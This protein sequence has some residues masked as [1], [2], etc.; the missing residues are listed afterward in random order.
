MYSWNIR[1][2]YP[3]R[4]RS[5]SL[6]ELSENG[7]ML[8]SASSLLLPHRLLLAARNFD[9]QKSEDM[10][11]KVRPCAHEHPVSYT[12][13][14][15]NYPQGLSTKAGASRPVLSCVSSSLPLHPFLPQTR[16]PHSPRPGA[17]TPSPV[18]VPLGW[19]WQDPGARGQRGVACDLWG[20]Q[21]SGPAVP[22]QHV[23]FRKLQ[24]LDNILQ[25]KPSEVSPRGVPQATAGPSTHPPR[26][27][28]RGSGDP[29]WWAASSRA[30]APRPGGPAVR[31]RWPVRL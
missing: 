2:A 28:A 31:R 21:S 4:P 24:D 16:V 8:H 9:L 12:L 27:A 18:L 26:P 20:R 6:Y 10:L 15:R 25:W 30:L 13:H 3:P 14:P 17:P 5:L 1:K 23:E 22:P 29:A 7:L 11:R 19:L